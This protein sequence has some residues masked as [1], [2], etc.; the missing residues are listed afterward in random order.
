VLNVL[1]RNSVCSH[2]RLA[3]LNRLARRGLGRFH[4]WTWG[5]PAAF[6]R[7]HPLAVAHSHHLAHERGE[8][9]EVPDGIVFPIIASLSEFAVQK[10]KG[11]VIDPP[12]VLDDNELVSVATRAYQEIAKSKPE[13]MG[14]TKACYSAVQQIM[15]IYKKLANS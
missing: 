4:F 3:R 8:I 6:Q 1:V 12:L 10:P 9:E 13:I 15:S 14:K 5:Q 11:W 7:A 2:F